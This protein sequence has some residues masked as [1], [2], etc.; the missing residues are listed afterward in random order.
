MRGSNKGRGHALGEVAH[1]N[2]SY[3]F[4]NRIGMESFCLICPDCSLILDQSISAFK[5]N[6]CM[7]E[8]PIREGVVCFLDRSDEFYEGAYDATINITFERGRS[9]K[10]LLYF[11]LYREPYLSAIRKYARSGSTILDLGC[12]GGTR[13]LS[14]KGDVVGVDLSF[15]SLR[16]AATFYNIGIQ[17]DALKLPFPAETFDLITGC[18]C[19]EH[20]PREGKQYLLKQMYRVLKPGGRVIL[21]FDCDND[22]PLFRWLKRDRKLFREC[23]VEHDHHYGLE[24]ASANLE[25]IKDEGFS[26]LKYKGINKTI[27]QYLPV[28]GWMA[29]YRN[30]SKL[31]S[32]ACC[33]FSIC[34]RH[35]AL[36]IPYYTLINNFDRMVEDM[37]PL[38]YARVLLVVGQKDK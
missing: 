16:K 2:L 17:A 31:I 7:R 9:L 27:F 37:V 11:H 26:I 4:C 12:G 1:V 33:V 13:Y 3:F 14:Q 24:T 10:G 34:A 38:D 6:G 18:Y 29:P 20:F 21:I 15:G 35:K 25:L 30:K 22:N 19:F 28:Y 5:C 23:F 8:Y 32:F 36:W